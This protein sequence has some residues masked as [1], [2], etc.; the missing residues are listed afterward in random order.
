MHMRSHS[1]PNLVF[2]HGRMR[3]NRMIIM[4]FSLSE[5]IGVT[6]EPSGSGYMAMSS[7]NESNQAS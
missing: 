7:D 6:S 5:I 4:V 1:E 2:G 3:A